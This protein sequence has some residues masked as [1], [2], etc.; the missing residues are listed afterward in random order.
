MES[1]QGTLIKLQHELNAKDE[2]LESA[3]RVSLQMPNSNVDKDLK[4]RLDMGV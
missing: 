1:L 2:E 3:K 4:L